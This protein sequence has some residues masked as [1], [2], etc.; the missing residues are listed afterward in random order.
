[1]FEK[2]RAKAKP[3]KSKARR[4][5]P[6]VSATGWKSRLRRG[7]KYEVLMA[8]DSLRKIRFTADDVYRAV[9]SLF[10]TSRITRSHISSLLWKLSSSDE[11]KYRVNS[12]YKVAVSKGGKTRSE[13][14]KFASESG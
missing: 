6:F 9:Q 1:M 14:K 7:P 8:I 12:F 4:A 13:Y 5:E 2:Y 11:A 10:P 3:K